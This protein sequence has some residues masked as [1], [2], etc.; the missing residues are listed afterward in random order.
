MN[1][2]RSSTY[3]DHA[4]ADAENI[5]G[6]FG[7]IRTGPLIVGATPTP[8]YPAASHYQGADNAPAEPIGIDVSAVEPV[9]TAA[10]IAASME[11]SDGPTDDKD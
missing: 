4:L 9:G 1:Q 11:Q 8:N 3:L 6:R 7:R 10:E 2:R 5:G